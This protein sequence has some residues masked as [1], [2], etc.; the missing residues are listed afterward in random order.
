METK[1]DLVLKDFSEELTYEEK[2]KALPPHERVLQDKSFID[3]TRP[4][5]EMIQYWEGPAYVRQTPRQMIRDKKR[6]IKAVEKLKKTNEYENFLADREAVFK[7]IE[8]AYEEAKA[9]KTL[10]KYP[11][12]YIDDSIRFADIG[13]QKPFPNPS[14]L[15]VY[16]DEDGYAV[17][18]LKRFKNKDMSSSPSHPYEKLRYLPLD[19]QNKLHTEVL[20]PGISNLR[21]KYP[22][23]NNLYADL[24]PRSKK[25]FKAYAKEVNKVNRKSDNIYN[26]R[27]NDY[28]Y[29]LEKPIIDQ[30]MKAALKSS[31][32]EA[33][34]RAKKEGTLIN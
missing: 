25:E 4:L 24:D 29:G 10:R 34:E 20:V 27:R 1:L 21:A 19:V 28:A 5:N 14:V 16:V 23:V 13:R 31:I 6:S 3:K 11:S 33:Y 12:F 32:D 30:L 26:S 8:D 7:P 15:N 22:K 17:S 2:F 18:S 9:N